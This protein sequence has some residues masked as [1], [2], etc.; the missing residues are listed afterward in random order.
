MNDESLEWFPAIM[1]GE[2]PFSA[3]LSIWVKWCNMNCSSPRTVL[4][5]FDCLFSI[6]DDDVC[7]IVSNGRVVSPSEPA[8]S[9]SG[10]RGAPVRP[11]SVGYASHA[12][13]AF[14]G[15]GGLQ[16]IRPLTLTPSQET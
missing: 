15:G 4:R 12:V 10:I 2:L 16:P 14:P 6:D 8:V 3:A 11:P 5:S 9:A 7:L 13:G 1:S